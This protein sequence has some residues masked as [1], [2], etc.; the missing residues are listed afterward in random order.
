MEFFQILIFF[1]Y[2]N[3]RHS[4][5]RT[6]SSSHPQL[7]HVEGRSR[8][9]QGTQT[10]EN[11]TKET[12]NNRLKSLKLQLNVGPSALNLRLVTKKCFPFRN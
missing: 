1:F 3:F 12:R 9:D 11:I 4:S 10:P 2:F 6:I 8:C 7:H 5:L